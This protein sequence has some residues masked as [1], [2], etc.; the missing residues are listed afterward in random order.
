MLND[1]NDHWVGELLRELNGKLSP[2]AIAEKTLRKWLKMIVKTGPHASFAKL[3]VT[4][5]ACNGKARASRTKT[6]N[7]NTLK[8]VC[9]YACLRQRRQARWNSLLKWVI[10]C[11]LGVIY[12]N[13]SKS[14]TS[15]TRLKHLRLEIHRR[16]QKLQKHQPQ[17][18]CQSMSSKLVVAPWALFPDLCMRL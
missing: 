8:D 5:E 7:N 3:M 13:L 11:L 6:A 10:S 12:Q 9:Q 14:K 16:R 15:K 17:T 1:A 2:K 4:I 18:C